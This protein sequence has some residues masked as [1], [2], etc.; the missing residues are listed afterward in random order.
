MI[1]Y[2]KHFKIGNTINMT[3]SFKATNNNILKKYIKMWWEKNQ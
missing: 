1:G 2:V 3:V